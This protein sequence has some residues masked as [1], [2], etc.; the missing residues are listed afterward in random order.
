MTTENA[1]VIIGTLIERPEVL[2]VEPGD[3]FWS[4]FQ[5]ITRTAEA[6]AE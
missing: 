4:I 3:Q 1:C 2:V 5:K 6:E